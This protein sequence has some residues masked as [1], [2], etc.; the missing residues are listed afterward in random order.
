[1]KKISIVVPCYCEEKNIKI[2][3]DEI[4]RVFKKIKI[5]L[6]I[7]FIDDGS[8]DNTLKVIKRLSKD[9]SVNYLSFSRNFGKEGAILA[10][11]RY[12]TGDYITTMDVDMQDPPSLL[13]EMLE[14]IEKED[15]DIICT[16]RV[17]RRGEPLIRSFF[18][19]CFY[20]IINK[21]SQVEF[22]DGV[23]DF[24]LMKREVVES[25][26]SMTEYNRFSKGI[27][28][29]VGFK[30]KYLEYPNIERIN[31][32][33]KWSFWALFKYAIEGIVSFTTVPLYISIFFGILFILT[34]I[35]LMI[36]FIVLKKTIMYHLIWIISLLSGIILI[37]IGILSLYLSKMYMEVKNRPHYIIKE[38]KINEKN[39]RVRKKA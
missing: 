1:M 33:S 38:K 35:V 26:L 8:S 18:A 10:G 28:N 27:F 32:E 16:R 6:E 36:I 29:F 21:M 22:V 13:P 15:Y 7:I 24:R 2:F 25:I 17:N 37:T 31:G 4:K 23:R 12:V 39:K 30:K 20:K 9:S 3:Y 14:L 34:S 11:L 5:E 19:R